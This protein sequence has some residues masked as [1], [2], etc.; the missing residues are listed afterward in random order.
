[1]AHQAG[2]AD[3]KTCESTWEHLLQRRVI[4]GAHERDLAVERH[5]ILQAQFGPLGIGIEGGPSGFT[6][7]AVFIGKEVD[8]RVRVIKVLPYGHNVDAVLFEYL[9][10]AFAE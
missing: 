6:R 2:E 9:D 8:E 7:G 4:G 3:R 1:M 5:E 10:L